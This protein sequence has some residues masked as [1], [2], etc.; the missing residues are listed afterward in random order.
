MPL[1]SL[2]YYVPTIRILKAFLLLLCNSAEQFSTI[3]LLKLFIINHSPLNSTAINS[4]ILFSVIPLCLS[5]IASVFC[6]PHFRRTPDIR[7]GKQSFALSLLSGYSF[8]LTTFF[9]MRKV[10]FPFKCSQLE[11][12]G[13]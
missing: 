7:F 13:L 12:C 1:V 3:F 4:L 5:I 6:P 10:L 11:S 2:I 9:Y 8:S